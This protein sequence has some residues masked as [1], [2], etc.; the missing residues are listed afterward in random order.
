MDGEGRWR[1]TANRRLSE[2]AA[3]L[4]NEWIANDRQV[5]ALL[6]QMRELAA[7]AAG[8]ILREAGDQGR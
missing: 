5:R 8:L 6:A 4:Y 2:R 7:K 1:K 3:Q